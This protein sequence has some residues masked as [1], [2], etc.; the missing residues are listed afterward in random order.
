M[1][2]KNQKL[3]AEIG[4]TVR[5][6][7]IEENK[8]VFLLSSYKQL[9]FSTTH[10]VVE[11]RQRKFLQST[12][13]HT[14]LIL[15][16]MRHLLCSQPILDTGPGSQIQIYPS[17]HCAL[18]SG[19]NE[20]TNQCTDLRLERRGWESLLML[21]GFPPT[22]SQLCHLSSK[23]QFRFSLVANSTNYSSLQEYFSFSTPNGSWMSFR[24]KVY[25]T[26]LCRV[27]LSSCSLYCFILN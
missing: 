20:Q 22:A 4:S 15:C 19:L 10:S 26:S 3:W 11:G 17:I 24:M 23:M 18:V 8:E 27:L 5:Y 21:R 9:P 12:C 13:P 2:F 6:E 25:V 16:T 14:R 1:S 7:R